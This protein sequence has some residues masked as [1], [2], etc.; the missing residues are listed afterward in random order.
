MANWKMKG[1]YLKNCNCL[2]SCPCDTIGTPEPHGFC[3]GLGGMYVQ[4]GNFDG[5]NLSG[6]K[7]AIAYHW[8]GAL[9]EGNG[10]VEAFIDEQTSEEQRNVLLQILSGQAGGTMF[11]IFAAIAPNFKGVQFVPIRW[12]FDKE[13]RRAQLEITG[14]GETETAPLTV[15]PTGEEQRVIV[16][17]PN[18][19]EY[20]EME[21]AQAVTLK[22]TGAIKF[23][24]NKTHSSL[25][26]VEH[27]H[28][29]LVA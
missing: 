17:M 11:E 26:E 13:R 2:A 5:V 15:I 25:A 16:K 3:E 18:G 23:E 14:I 27:T 8:P 10:D 22:S 24:W 21:V 29:G 20:K 28:E 4:E 9:H 12:E 1:Q 19:F 7:W 6:V